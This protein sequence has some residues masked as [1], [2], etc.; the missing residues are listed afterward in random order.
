LEFKKGIP[1]CHANF[2]NQP[3]VQKKSHPK[4]GGAI[5]FLTLPKIFVQKQILIKRNADKSISS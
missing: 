2:L 1:D 5:F 3:V 4:A